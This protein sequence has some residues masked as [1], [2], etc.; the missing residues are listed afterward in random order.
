MLSYE[1]KEK[2]A[3][4]MPTSEKEIIEAIRRNECITKEAVLR[5][6]SKKIKKYMSEAEENPKY[7]K[8]YYALMVMFLAAFE[9]K[10]QNS[11][12]FDNLPD[13][14]VYELEYQYDEFSLNIEHYKEYKLEEDGGFR[15]GKLDAVYKLISL[16]PDSFSVEQYA[17]FYEVEQGTVRQWIRRGKIRT[18]YKEGSEWKIPQLSPPP[19]RGYEGAQYKWLNGI[20]NLPEEY[21]FLAD[22][23]IATFYQDMKDKT[24]YHVLFVSKETFISDHPEDVSKTKNKELLLSA[25]EREKLELFMIAHPQIKY[26]GLVI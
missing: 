22:Y 24:K 12:L 13:Y 19:S 3:E 2:G 9:E 8:T 6:L 1:Y 5:K 7:P 20:D 14:W 15:T 4:N 17:K 21:A 11:V 10:I 25:P 18:A 16:R 23:V 26:C